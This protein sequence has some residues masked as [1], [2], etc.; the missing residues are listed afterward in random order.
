MLSGVMWQ[1]RQLLRRLLLPLGGVGLVYY[2]YRDFTHVQRGEGVAAVDWLPASASNV[3]KAFRPNSDCHWGGPSHAREAA[4]KLR[5]VSYGA[6]AATFGR[7]VNVA[8]PA[9]G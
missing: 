6:K 1:P 2:A 8:G 7:M 4:E 5:E 3:G 9:A